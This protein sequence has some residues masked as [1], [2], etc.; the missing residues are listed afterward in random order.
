[1]LRIR[2][3]V[4]A[5]LAVVLFGCGGPTPGPTCLDGVRN[6]A[7]SDVDCGGASCE[8]C[9]VGKACS[10]AADCASGTCIG[11]TC[12][13]PSDD[14]GSIQP[15][16]AGAIDGG[17]EVDAGVDA[18]ADAGSGTDAGA[19]DAGSSADAGADAG[20]DAG[21]EL[22]GG[23]A[24]AGFVD[25]GLPFDAGVADAGVADA[26]VADAGSADA[27]T[28]GGASDAG[29]DAGASVDGGTL[30]ADGIR[31]GT[32]TGIDCG[33][34]CLN[35]PT[36]L[37]QRVPTDFADSVA[38]LF[39]GA[40]PAQVGVQPG[41]ISPTRQAVLRGQVF[42]RSGA[43]LQGVTISVR[44]EPALGSTTSRAT[45]LYELVVN[46][47]SW[48]TL[49]FSL[50]NTLPAQRQVLTPMRGYA[51]VDDVALV[52]LDAQVTT[53]TL[54][55]PMMQTHLSTPETDANGTR[56]ASLMFEA[57]TQATMLV[58]GVPQPLPTLHVRATE[59]TVGPRGREAMPG[60]LPD[61]SGY[62][63]AVELSVDEAI[64]A[65]ATEVRFSSPVAIHVNNFLGFPVG[66]R[67]PVG[68][69][70]RA[71]SAWIPSRNGRVVKILSVTAGLADLDVDGSMTAATAGILTT[72][73]ISTD[74]R[75]KL[76]LAFPVG[77]SLWR[78]RLDHFTPCDMNLPFGVVGNGE[79]PPP[80]P[81]K[82]PRVPD[83]C[84]KGGSVLRCEEQSL[85]ESIPL[86]GTPFDLHFNSARFSRQSTFTIPVSGSSVPLGLL[87]I[88]VE[89]QVLGRLTRASLLPTP[90]QTYTFR[91]DG[92]DAW[93][94]P[95]F[96]ETVAKG[97][98][99]YVYATAYTQ[100]PDALASFGLPTEVL[101]LYVTNT[102]RMETSLVREFTHTFDESRLGATAGLGGWSLSAHHAY[103]RGSLALGDGRTL[104]SRGGFG[105]VMTT[106]VGTGVAGFSGD[107]S[108][109]RL[110]QI[111]QPQ[112]IAI[113][114]DGSVYF[115]TEPQTAPRIRKLSPSGII[116]TFAGNGTNTF[117]V[118]GAQAT[119]TGLRGLNHLAMGP[120]GS[121]YLTRSNSSQFTGAYVDRIGADGSIRRLAGSPTAG[122]AEAGDEGPALDAAIMGASGLIVAP[123]SGYYI[124]GRS[125]VRYVSPDGVIHA[126]AGDGTDVSSGDDGP[127]RLAG[128]RFPTEVAL[129]SDGAILISEWG[130]IRRVGADGII[131]TVAGN[132]SINN[133][134]PTVD[135]PALTLPLS[136]NGLATDR[137]GTVYILE[138]GTRQLRVLRDGVLLTIGGVRDTVAFN[139][140]NRHPLD[141][142]I[143][144]AGMAWHPDGSLYVSDAF[145]HRLRKIAL[146][147]DDTSI[148]SPDAS[149]TFV[150]TGQG[151]HLRTLD[152]LT[153]VTKT[154]FTYD[155]AGRLATASTLGGVTTIERDVMGN[156]T[157][158]V[159]PT[160]Q[161]T[162]LGVGSTGFLSSITDP[163]GRVTGFTTLSTGE[164]AT[165]T[166]PA[167]GLYRFT[168]DAA[169]G[170]IRDEDPLGGSSS[171][172]SVTSLAGVKTTSWTSALGRTS[173]Y[174]TAQ[175]ALGANARTITSPT[176]AVSQ[177]SF[178][179]PGVTTVTDAWGVVE[180]TRESPH[181]RFHQL[182]PYLSQ[183]TV[184]A[185][186]GLTL[187]TTVVK[188][189]TVTNPADPFSVSQE[190]ETTTVNGRVFS[191][192]WNAAT[193]TVSLVSAAGTQSSLVTNAQGLITE[194]RLGAG[195]DPIVYTY[196]AQAR[197]T[198][199]TQGAALQVHGYD[200]LNRRTSTV[201]ANGRRSSYGYDATGRLTTA[202]LPSL[203]VY[204]YTYDANGYRTSVTMP[205]GVSNTQ[206]YSAVGLPTVFTAAGA[207]ALTKSYNVDRELT[208]I[209]YPSGRTVSWAHDATGR[210][211]TIGSPEATF[212][213][214]YV[215][216]SPRPSLVTRTPLVGTPQT[217]AATFDGQLITRMTFGGVALGQFDYRYDPNLF[218]VGLRIDATPE[219]LI[220]RNADG[221]VTTWGAFS[222]V[223]TGPTG[224]PTSIT[225]AGLSLA[226]GYDSTARNTR[227]TTSVAD[228]GVFDVT[229]TYDLSSVVTG[230]VETSGGSTRTIAYDHDVDRQLTAVRVNTVTVETYAYDVDGNRTSRTLGAAA[231]EAVTLDAQ[232][233]VIA[234]GALTFGYNADGQMTQR[235]S[236]LF[237]YTSR[238]ELM[239]A[240]V[241]GIPVT[242]AHDGLLRRVARTEAGQTRSFLYGNLEE[243]FQLTAT[244]GPEGL[245][246]FTY[247]DFGSLFSFVRA[248]VAYHVATD[249]LGSPRV[250]TTTT[251]TVVKTMDYDAF[252]N[253]TDSAPAFELPIGFAGGLAD[254]RTRLV[255]FGM[256]DYE[257]VIGRFTARD[258][259]LFES[260]N[261][262]LYLYVRNDP[263]SAK[264]PHGLASIAASLYSGF[265]GG[266]KLSATG[267]GV[268]LCI[269]AGYGV[270][271]TLDVKTSLNTD[272]DQPGAT[273]AATVKLKLGAASYT[274]G[275]QFTNDCGL[276]VKSELGLGPLSINEKGEVFGKDPKK[277]A[278]AISKPS[279]KA[280][281]KAYGQYC[282]RTLF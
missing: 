267:T 47:G 62:T 41:A 252:G 50:A 67:I 172:S 16:D 37:D 112:R 201:D 164:L 135:G 32:E 194:E 111:T 139:G 168:Y 115:T 10:A 151:R 82:P 150:F 94:R 160:G 264:D 269:E 14:A 117:P 177:S 79:R 88:E 202:T 119:Q 231:P 237:Q 86:T 242:Y 146:A 229:T 61:F 176:G 241:Q 124:V 227:R 149:E 97:R 78:A 123:D 162:L 260:E 95:V 9:A 246:V 169:G 214:G 126:F 72:L 275:G 171:F 218:L 221:N 89:V 215:G 25:A 170:V 98:V 165:M 155:A 140:D 175:T 179:A 15:V 128:C 121:L 11:A 249:A 212:T 247:D 230:R 265:G 51:N 54:P 75:T 261:P 216:T 45:G 132:G 253:V 34:S 235:G 133:I 137:G 38:F 64:A 188:T 20:I 59:Y 130:R 225:G 219:T 138:G 206:V 255:R 263:V 44:G 258:P 24:D 259:L 99:L 156:P 181:P 244:K 39:T 114:P 161:R 192:T 84:E 266:F 163:A 36:P 234:Q 207:G 77:T 276:K 223:R 127:A 5:V 31:N 254:A 80:I 69:Y 193:R 270:G 1:M 96:G 48:V 129:A 102:V 199:T 71:K 66:S 42:D 282:F 8:P 279:F 187:N 268:S 101:N 2:L 281:A 13:A 110:A 232:K 198:G 190:T 157:A 107:G 141:S 185:P 109:G 197:R 203:R 85:G 116:T 136:V 236:D 238:G 152:G 189:A 65:G 174:G 217:L 108:A 208:S 213:H 233:R 186:S 191:S 81:P 184:R 280:E 145:N 63:Y 18:G 209:V 251:G 272:L 277:A 134:P 158:V 55:A 220:T 257:P 103:D 183:R 182:A 91:W 49:D 245:T 210:V 29:V 68:F 35:C 120:D 23:E 76:A 46:G 200:A 40:N 243:P 57:G 53:I 22:D 228:A 122:G 211:A 256:R 74:E 159:A 58:G 100:P 131:R 87:R 204:S 125:R 250:V 274:F 26:G 166:T 12:A 106:V 239:S 19:D 240:T 28:D 27:G 222:M 167:G 4:V 205:S 224:A 17:H 73:G 180:T 226:L 70:D 148:P 278:E 144:P 52:T 43:P 196:D 154:Q 142:N 104:P 248:G 3:T 83:P 33:G 7:E 147:F 153:G 21:P 118:D 173:S 92:L 178:A 6:A 60:R 195:I 113:G 273:L 30:C 90:N 93:A 262:N 105:N 271:G 143:S 56:R